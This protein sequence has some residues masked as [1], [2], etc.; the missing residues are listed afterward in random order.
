MKILLLV[1]MFVSLVVPIAGEPISQ[2]KGCSDPSTLAAGLQKLPNNWSEVSIVQLQKVWPTRLKPIDCA[3]GQECSM[4]HEGRII[5]G[6]FECG[7]VF[8]FT[9]SPNGTET[10]RLQSIVIHFTAPTR[11]ETVTAAKTLAAALGLV[12]VDEVTVGRA[13]QQQFQWNLDHELVSLD[14]RWTRLGSNWNLYL[15]SAHYQR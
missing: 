6:E 4:A 13:D 12:Q 2:L 15:S 8:D 3:E 7:E 11:E 9:R 10:E 14:L 5:N 1:A